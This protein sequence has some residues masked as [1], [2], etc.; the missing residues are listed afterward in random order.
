M[1]LYAIA[2]LLLTPCWAAI[3]KQ[4][5]TGTPHTTNTSAGTSCAITYTPHATG[6]TIVLSLSAATT[7]ISAVSGSDNATGGSSTYTAIGNVANSGATGITYLWVAQSV[8]A[9]ATTFTASWTTSSRNS[10][11]LVEYSGVVGLGTLNKTNTGSTSPMNI[12]IATTAPNSWVVMA[13][14]VR[15][16]ATYSA[17]TG[18]SPTSTCTLQDSIAGGGSTTNGDATADDGNVTASGTNTTVQTILSSA[19]AWAVVGIELRSTSPCNHAVSLMHAGC[20]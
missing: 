8:K 6:D 3:A 1:K 14:G 11:D 9:G 10:C 15:G 5:G 18:C 4:T 16:T 17:G 13:G 19:S 2:L 20:M 7:T 12:S